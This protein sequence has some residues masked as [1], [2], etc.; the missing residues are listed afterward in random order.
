[1]DWTPA[2]RK[3]AW[4]RDISFLI[5]I[6]GSHAAFYS[7]EIR[8]TPQRPSSGFVRLTIYLCVV[9]CLRMYG[10]IPFTP[11][12][13]FMACLG[14]LHDFLITAHIIIAFHKSPC[15]PSEKLIYQCT[16]SPSHVYLNLCDWDGKGG[17]FFC[18]IC[19][20]CF[21]VVQVTHSYVLP[22][23]NFAGHKLRKQYIRDM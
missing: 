21:S 16:L 12:C 20:L 7:L 2:V 19:Q 4:V 22:V 10:A 3:L 13:A 8:D 9:T 18:F 5:N 14:K 11:P 23:E 15:C 1:M 17:V 6:H